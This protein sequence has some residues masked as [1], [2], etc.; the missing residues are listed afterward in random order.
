MAPNVTVAVIVPVFDGEAF[1]AQALDSVARQTRPPDEVVVVDDGST[2]RSAEIAAGR[3]GVRVVRQSN[4]GV[5]AARNAGVGA[6]ASDLVAFLDQ[7]DRYTPEKIELQAAR[8]ESQPEVAY[9]LAHQRLF[10]ETGCEPPG[11]LRP[12]HLDSRQAG[13]LPGTLMARRTAFESVGAFDETKLSGSDTDWLLRAKDRGLASVLMPEVLLERR[14]HD[15]NQSAQV[16]LG[17][18]DLLAAVRASL[19]RRRHGDA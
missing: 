9:V 6:T 18:R 10:L 12:E 5:A 13:Y 17:H 11:W 4:R 19:H 3:P 7:D 1:L 8:L 14:I 16:A 15:A 2:D